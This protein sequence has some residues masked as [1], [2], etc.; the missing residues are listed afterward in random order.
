MLSKLTHLFKLCLL[1]GLFLLV[2]CAPTIEPLS[3]S[4]PE[5]K[6]VWPKAPES[7]RIKL[8]RRLGGIDDL[9][10]KTKRKNRLFR[11]LTGEMAEQMPLVA[12]YGIATNGLGTLWI[13]DPGAHVVHVFDLVRRTGKLWT[14]AG[15]RFLSSPTGIC[16]DPASQKVYVADS[17]LKK[18]F[19]FSG[20]GQ[21]QGEIIANPPFGRPGGLAIDKQGNLLVA[22]V[23]NGVIRRFYSA[24]DQLSDFG[25]PTSANGLF[26]RPIGLTVDSTG[27]I[28]VIDSLNFKIEVLS[29][30]GEAV[31]SIGKLGDQPG[32][33][34]RPRG[35]AVDSFGHIYV[36]DAAFD[37]IQIFNLKGQLLLVF[38]D[39][40]LGLSMPASL[41]MDKQDRIY[42]VDSFNHQIQIYQFLGVDN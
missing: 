25:S 31:A 9:V 42:A 17:L 41:V 3:I 6:V 11:W 27:L 14:L 26:N 39:G 13:S 2:S 34:S 1:L 16:Y 35:V 18:V 10:D 20:T 7:P 36:A 21:Y 5:I 19:V 32:S 23:I 24:G 38:G 12:P 29:Q 8:L 4:D 30:S 22:D 28:Y 37:N 15:D 40:K 33:L